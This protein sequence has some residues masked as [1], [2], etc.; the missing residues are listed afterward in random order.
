MG[1]SKRDRTVASLND[2]FDLLA[3]LGPGM[4]REEAENASPTPEEW[5]EEIE[6][7]PRLGRILRRLRSARGLSLS[8]VAERTNLSIELLERLEKGEE[9]N[10]DLADLVEVSGVLGVPAWQI[11]RWVEA[12]EG[13]EAADRQ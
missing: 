13:H 9:M 10:P 3:A 5:L 2:A 7:L 11:V 8:D 12:G 4:S 1:E 6:E